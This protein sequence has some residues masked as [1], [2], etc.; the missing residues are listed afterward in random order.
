MH[1]TTKLYGKMPD[2]LVLLLLQPMG[3]ATRGLANNPMGRSLIDRSLP[4]LGRGMAFLGRKT[5]FLEQR[6][7]VDIA[8]ET[9]CKFFARDL[10]IV[11]A[12]SSRFEYT[13]EKC[14]YGLH[15]AEHLDLC[16]SM[17][18]WDEALIS[19]LGGKM[20]IIDRMPEGKPRCRMCITNT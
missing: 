18:K 11:E 20:E 5:N 17:M 1:K 13:L 9:V 12:T 16:H 8:Y 6:S 15:T 7:C 10:Q 4:L 3:V 14:P 2:G 19:A